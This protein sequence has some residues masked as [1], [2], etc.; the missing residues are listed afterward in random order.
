MCGVC[1]IVSYSSPPDLLLLRR[2]TGRIAHR[3]PDG[4]GYYRDRHAALGHTRLAIIDTAGGAQPLCNEDG[5]VW[6]TFNGEI[7]N[8]VEL[9][10]ELRGRGHTF[11]TAS[12]TEVIVHAWEQ[13]GEGCFSRFNGQWAIALWDR[14]AERLVL[15]RDRLGV[16]PLFFIR[17]RR[18]VCCSPPR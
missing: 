14:R 17:L 12:D 15:S 9:R 6:V 1:G 5:T 8:Y 7:F 4:N 10:E 11:R 18:Q 16:R 13:W 3:G 2:M